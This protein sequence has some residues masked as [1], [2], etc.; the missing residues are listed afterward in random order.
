MSVDNKTRERRAL[1]LSAFGA[2]IMAALGFGFAVL[3]RSEALMLDGLFSLL[4]FVMTLGAI[5]ISRL[6]YEPGNMQFQFGFAGFEPLFNLVKGLIIIFISLL[7][8]YSSSLAIEAGGREIEI[9]WALVYA[10]IVTIT[11]IIVFLLLSRAARKTGSPLLLVDAKNWMIDGAITA[12]VLVGFLVVYFARDTQWSWIVPYADPM[13]VLVLVVISLPIPFLIIKSSVKELLLGAP[14]IKLQQSLREK[15]LPRL[16]AAGYSTGGTRLAKTGR[17]IYL[18]VFIL[19]D[20]AQA[21]PSVAEQ[22]EFRSKLTAELGT[23][24]ADI[25]VDIFFTRDE[26]YG[27]L[28][29]EFVP[30]EDTQ[31]KDKS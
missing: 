2:L 22:D 18:Y 25:E 8:A 5:R 9:G 23:L 29:V 11:S 15:M 20:A 10:V 17:M 24:Y 31:H 6:V 3:T 30:F 26:T 12:A 7:A 21:D 14:D 4:G 13:V 16:K 28:N 1:I 27:G 19:L